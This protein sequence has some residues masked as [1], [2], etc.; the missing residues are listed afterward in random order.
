MN[1]KLLK[2]PNVCEVRT[3]T[4]GGLAGGGSFLPQGGLIA[5]QN[6]AIC[7]SRTTCLA[8]ILGLLFCQACVNSHH[9]KGGKTS[10]CAHFF[11]GGG[12]HRK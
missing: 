2:P 7:V 6:L 11:L 8:Y 10:K 3:Q 12:L 4:Q 9:P 1:L 5:Q